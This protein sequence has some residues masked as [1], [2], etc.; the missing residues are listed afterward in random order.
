MRDIR[1]LFPPILEIERYDSPTVNSV[2]F[3][4]YSYEEKTN[5]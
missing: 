4:N 2:D 3:F 5:S 1:N